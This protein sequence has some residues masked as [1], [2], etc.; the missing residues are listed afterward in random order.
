MGDGD[1]VC[2]VLLVV[3]VVYELSHKFLVR[4]VPVESNRSCLY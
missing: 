4:T 3:I 1:C 2:L